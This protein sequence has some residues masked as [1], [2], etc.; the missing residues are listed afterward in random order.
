MEHSKNEYIMKIL[1]FIFLIYSVSVFTQE[2]KD[3]AHVGPYSEYYA[4]GNV[5]VEGNFSQKQTK[6]GQWKAYFENG[7]VEKI[8]NYKRGA[9]VGE[10]KEYFP[11]GKLKVEGKYSPYRTKKEGVWKEFYE[12]GQLKFQA[13]Y[14]SGEFCG[15]YLKYYKNGNV[16]LKGEYDY[17]KNTRKGDWIEYFDDGSIKKQEFYN[18]NGILEGKSKSYFPNGNLKVVGEHDFVTGKKD[19]KWV[20]FYESG[21]T[22]SVSYFR[23]GL[24][25]GDHVEYHENGKLKIQCKYNF[26][27]KLHGTYQEMDENGETLSKGDYEEGEKTGKWFETNELGE[28]KKI[29]Y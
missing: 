16:S 7:T 4:N 5:K 20:Q 9:Q 11:S 21:D 29:K 17:F 19:G 14:H 18:S 26:S 24:Q 6:E 25:V 27:G 15:I 22:M 8:E 2:E 28:L 23:K 1:L 10:Y 13:Q 12:N 3:S